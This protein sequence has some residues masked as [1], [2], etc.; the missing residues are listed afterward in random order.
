MIL[1][2]ASDQRSV[3]IKG[4]F[5]RALLLMKCFARKGAWWF[6]PS[7]IEEIS[8]FQAGALVIHLKLLVIPC[9]LHRRLHTAWTCE[10]VKKIAKENSECICSV[11]CSS[12]L[13]NNLDTALSSYLVIR[14]E[15]AGIPKCLCVQDLCHR[16]IVKFL[17]GVR[18]G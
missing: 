11:L 10:S 1:H 4:P 18:D 9:D 6:A 13:P 2:A 5:V 16:R 15:S 8:R 3:R 17:H 14:A 12:S 7:R